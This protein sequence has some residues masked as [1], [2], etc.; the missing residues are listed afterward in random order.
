MEVGPVLAETAD[1]VGDIVITCWSGVGNILFVTNTVAIL[2]GPDR[3]QVRGLGID[4]PLPFPL[5]PSSPGQGNATLA[6]GVPIPNRLL[7]GSSKAEGRLADTL[8]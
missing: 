2:I 5:R 1:G 6:E 4:G 7:H 3:L 8:R